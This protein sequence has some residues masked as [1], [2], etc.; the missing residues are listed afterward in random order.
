MD[1]ATVVSFYTPNW[2][3]PAHAQRL[4]AECDALG[5]SWRIVPRPDT[6]TYP[7]NCRHKPEVLQEARA[8]LSGPILWVD[9]DASVLQ[10]PTFHADA[11]LAAYPKPEADPRKWHVGTLWLNDTPGARDFLD[12][13]ATYL[14]DGASDELALHRMWEAGAWD[15]TWSELPEAYFQMN[16]HG[17][18]ERAVIVHRLSNSDQKRAFQRGVS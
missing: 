14:R 13:W 5:V 11:D 12:V 7:G 2:E 18:D 16:R 9:V 8:A 1:S 15:G 6:G 3:Y 17:Y 10:R 4:A